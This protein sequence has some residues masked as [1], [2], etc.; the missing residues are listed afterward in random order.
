M[1]RENEYKRIDSR[2]LARFMRIPN[3]ANSL[4]VQQQSDMNYRI[5]TASWQPETRVVYDAVKDGYTEQESLKVA[6]GL[7]D[8]QIRDS[9]AWLQ[10]K[11]YIQTNL[12]AL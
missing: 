7:T 6:T 12:G 10:S 4:T 3:F 1:I 2:Q 11:G 9:L 5:L 8:Q